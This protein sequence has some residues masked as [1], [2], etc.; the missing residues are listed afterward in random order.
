LANKN[1][2]A[3]N[4][5]SVYAVGYKEA[6]NLIAEQIMGKRVYKKYAMIY[7]I[8]YLYR[9]YL[10]IQLK[11]IISLTNKALERSS[12][13]H[14][15]VVETKKFTENHKLLNLYKECFDKIRVFAE[16]I[17][18]QDI[19]N[20]ERDFAEFKK[21]IEEFEKYDKSSTSFRY[22]LKRNGEANLSELDLLNVKNVYDIINKSTETFDGI[23]WWLDHQIETMEEQISYGCN[24]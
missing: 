14:C 23:E 19:L 4:L 10:E 7:P 1:I 22:P 11:N 17:G 8:M 21:V 15:S 3:D 12:I 5:W 13:L 16:E 20:E 2:D 18:D 9:H 6:A 24:L